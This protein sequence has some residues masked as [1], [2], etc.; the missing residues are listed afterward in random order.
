M[1]T[2]PP[3]STHMIDDYD[4]RE[5]LL[6][7]WRSAVLLWEAD[8]WPLGLDVFPLLFFVI[9]L[10]RFALDVVLVALADTCPPARPFFGFGA[11]VRAS[12]PSLSLDGVRAL[13]SGD[14]YCATFFKKPR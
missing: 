10:S 9:C 7:G 6:S 4:G 11:G 8:T 3:S 14:L 1:E 13:P 12:Q 5:R 2:T